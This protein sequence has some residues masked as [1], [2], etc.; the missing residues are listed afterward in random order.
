LLNSKLVPI[1]ANKTSPMW[2]YFAMVKDR[3]IMR[4]EIQ[5]VYSRNPSLGLVTKAKVCKT[6]RQERDPRVWE[7]VRVNSH[8]PKWTPMLG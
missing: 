3:P 8:T 4:N 6:L 5:Y 1:N 2:E 7:S